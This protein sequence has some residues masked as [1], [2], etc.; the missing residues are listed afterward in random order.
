MAR[1]LDKSHRARE[2]VAHDST[3]GLDCL[4][5][6]LQQIQMWPN[7]SSTVSLVPMRAEGYPHTLV[8][9]KAAVGRVQLNDVYVNEGALV[10]LSDGSFKVAHKVAN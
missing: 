7:D 3:H 10:K 8:E 1:D 6:C 4:S 2:S 5:F 9:V